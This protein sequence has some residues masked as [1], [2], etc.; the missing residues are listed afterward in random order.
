MNSLQK[1][2]SSGKMP[3]SMATIPHPK[4]L[5]KPVTGVRVEAAVTEFAVTYQPD[6]AKTR[7]YYS[8]EISLCWNRAISGIISMGF[9]LI[10][11]KATLSP[12]DWTILVKQD[13]PFDLT[14]ACR[15]MQIAGSERI[16]DAEISKSLPASWDKLYQLMKLDD[17]VFYYGIRE[18]IIHPKCQCKDIQKTEGPIQQRKLESGGFQPIG[19][20]GTGADFGCEIRRG[21]R[22]RNR[23]FG[24]C[25]TFGSEDGNQESCRES[26]GEE[27]GAS[28]SWQDLK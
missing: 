23:C 2:E 15:I 3:I 16:T 19:I 20:R 1:P 9:L 7:A 22:I 27:Y 24:C 17:D 11:A 10:E 12:V 14:V 13:C 5:A 28:G 26:P 6:P 21:R 8:R 4:P 18:G 25:V